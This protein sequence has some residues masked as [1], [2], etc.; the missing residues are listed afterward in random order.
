M[1][2]PR[3]TRAEYQA[4]L[5]AAVQSLQHSRGAFNE[6]EYPLMRLLVADA[7]GHLRSANAVLAQRQGPINEQTT[8]HTNHTKG[9]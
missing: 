9:K 8:K 2:S 5:A 7:L 1:N 6:G 4:H 3:Q